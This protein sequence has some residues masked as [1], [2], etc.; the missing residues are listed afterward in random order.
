[1]KIFNWFEISL[2]LGTILA[3]F[4]LTFGNKIDA[5]FLVLSM[6]VFALLGIV[7][8]LRVIYLAR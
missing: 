4:H 3:S 1:M 2:I 6:I 5:I 7:A 8:Y